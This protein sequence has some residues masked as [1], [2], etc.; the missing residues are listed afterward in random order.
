MSYYFPFGGSQAATT[1]NISHSLSAVTASAPTSNTITVITASYAAAS[2][3]TPSAGF[4]GLSVTLEICQ[5]SASANPSLLVSGATGNQGPTGSKGTDVLTCP[6]G[7]VR[8]INLEPSL[9]AQFNVGGIR[10]ANYNVP[11]GSQYSI[12]CMQIPTTCSAAQALAGCPDSL[13]IPTPRPS[14]P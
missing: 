13:Y 3:S 14:I 8:C 2:G 7:T 4:A 11:S 12:V 10:G 5:A 1:Q 6:D 9:S